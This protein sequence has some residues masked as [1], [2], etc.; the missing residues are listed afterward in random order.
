MKRTH[1]YA[2]T[3]MLAV[4]LDQNANPMK[5]ESG[6]NNIKNFSLYLTGNMLHPHYEHELVNADCRNHPR[7][8]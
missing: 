1:T 7:L 6:L 3:E 8:F 2:Y 5:H 4:L